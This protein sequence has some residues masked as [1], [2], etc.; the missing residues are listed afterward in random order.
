MLLSIA[1]LFSPFLFCLP[2]THHVLEKCIVVLIFFLGFLAPFLMEAN[3]GGLVTFNRA[4]GRDCPGYL[5]GDL[6][7]RIAFV[8]IQEWWGLNE[9]LK[10]LAKNIFVPKGHRVLIPDLYRG[11]IATDNEEADHLMRGLD[12]QG[13]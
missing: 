8:V 6:Q 7:A 13:G 3:E 4:D 5:I 2:C 1:V 12:W 11:K 9:Q 10:R